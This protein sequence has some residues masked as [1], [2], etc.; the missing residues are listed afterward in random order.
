MN[1]QQLTTAEQL[2]EYGRLVRWVLWKLA[3]DDR[4]VSRQTRIDTEYLFSD[5]GWV[6]K[7]VGGFAAHHVSKEDTVEWA[8]FKKM[9][10]EKQ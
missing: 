3:T 1:Q 9:V 6:S 4:E 5:H 10:E 2:E 7:V 8:A